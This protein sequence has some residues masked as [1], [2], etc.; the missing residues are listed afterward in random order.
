[1]GKKR[2]K[3]NIKNFLIKTF[4]FQNFL[5]KRMD[6]PI[7][8]ALQKP[9]SVRVKYL[10]P[11]LKKTYFLKKV[12]FR[13]GRGRPKNN[14]AEYK[15][16]SSLGQKRTNYRRTSYFRLK[17]NCQIPVYDKTGKAINPYIDNT[18]YIKEQLGPKKKVK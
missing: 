11:P 4:L 13:K 5:K 10:K 14:M 12:C 15:N 6:Y 3:T 7:Q 17:K 16:K 9:L 8:K 2:C 18:K 1:M